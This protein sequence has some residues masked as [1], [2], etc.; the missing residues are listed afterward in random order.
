MQQRRLQ[1]LFE[2]RDRTR[3]L[4]S[5]YV[6][7]FRNRSEGTRLDHPGKDAHAAD[8]ICHSLTQAK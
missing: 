8:D 7:L 5:R 2:R 1:L 6:V 4:R 3:N